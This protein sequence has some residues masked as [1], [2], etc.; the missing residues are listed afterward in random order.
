MRLITEYSSPKSG[1]D[2]LRQHIEQERKP[3]NSIVRALAIS[4]A[5]ISLSA[6]SVSSGTGS[7]N[8]PDDLVTT[9]IAEPIEPEGIGSDDAEII[10]TAVAD[11]DDAALLAWQN[12]DSGNK[13][14]ITAIDQFVGSD[15]QQCK[16]FQT[17][18][19]TFMGISLYNG[20]TCEL[21]QGFWVLSWF[22]KAET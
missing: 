19:D 9:S 21:R 20:E 16:K 6:C 18:V 7:V 10:K 1:T 5:L 2:S 3:V 12:P 8:T 15:G 4:A 14:T 22:L 13:G 11:A 17:T